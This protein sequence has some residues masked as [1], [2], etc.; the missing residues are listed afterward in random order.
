MLAVEPTLT[1]LEIRQILRDTAAKVG[2]YD[3]DWDPGMPGHSLE[4]GYGRVDAQAAVLA[5][6]AGTIFADGFESG[7]VSAWS[8]VSP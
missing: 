6:S 4:L 3:Y 1:N 7:D 2:G 8:E 5:A